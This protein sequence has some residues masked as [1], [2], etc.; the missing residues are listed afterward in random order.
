MKIANATRYREIASKRMARVMSMALEIDRTETKH[1]SASA[2]PVTIGT[3]IGSDRPPAMAVTIRIPKI[4]SLGAGSD[5]TTASSAK[6]AT[7]TPAGAPYASTVITTVTARPGMI[8]YDSGGCRPP[9]PIAAAA[10]RK[11]APRNQT[12]R[13]ATL[14][15]GAAR[16]AMVGP[17][18][19]AGLAPA[20]SVRAIRVVVDG[21]DDQ[22]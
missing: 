12:S 6:P 21:G 18:A 22:P 2:I 14:T 15:S 10:P 8:R 16:V 3:R 1:H 11:I 13:P 19:M 4:R 17:A 9:A 7:V 20:V 5:R